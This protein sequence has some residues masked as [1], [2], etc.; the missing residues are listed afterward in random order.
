MQFYLI[1]NKTVFSYETPDND[2]NNAGIDIVIIVLRSLRFDNSLRQRTKS[3]YRLKNDSLAQVGR[4]CTSC[5]H[6]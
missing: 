4:I 2:I 3:I 1:K 5:L 6:L